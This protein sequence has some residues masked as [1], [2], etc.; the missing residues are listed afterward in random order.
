MHCSSLLVKKP[1]VFQSKLQTIV[2]TK[3]KAK[4]LTSEI[5]GYSGGRR[6]VKCMGWKYK[7]GGE[8]KE[9]CDTFLWGA[10]HACIWPGHWNWNII[11]FVLFLAIDCQYQAIW[12]SVWWLELGFLWLGQVYAL[13]GGWGGGRTADQTSPCAV[14]RESDPSNV[15]E[16]YCDTPAGTRKKDEQ[17]FP[18]WIFYWATFCISLQ[19]KSYSELIVLEFESLAYSSRGRARVKI[20]NG[21][22]QEESETYVVLV[23]E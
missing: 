14:G 22:S 23:S 12:A 2:H 16:V 18:H 11:T 15:L 3:S 1:H 20:A 6:W 8:I 4:G 19:K 17:I 7:L 9:S 10:T 13:G 21:S 5:L